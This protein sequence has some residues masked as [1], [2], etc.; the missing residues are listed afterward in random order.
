MQELSGGTYCGRPLE[1]HAGASTASSAQKCIEEAMAADNVEPSKRVRLPL[2]MGY[3]RR[4]LRCMP[5]SAELHRAAGAMGG[6]G[7]GSV[8]EGAENSV[9]SLSGV[10]NSASS[11]Q[12]KPQSQEK[13]EEAAAE[14]RSHSSSSTAAVTY[15]K[16]MVKSAVV[17]S[18]KAA[19]ASSV[20]KPVVA[21]A[22]E[23]CMDVARPK[24]S[25]MEEATASEKDTSASCRKSVSK[26]VMQVPS[27]SSAADE[28]KQFPQ[29]WLS[30][31][32]LD[33]SVEKQYSVFCARQQVRVSLV[34][35]VS[36]TRSS[37]RFVL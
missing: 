23:S 29:H 18:E 1:M 3:K 8:P 9:Q 27:V 16:M 22:E 37:G 10:E 15:L 31:Q 34:A 5:K 12:H 26:A 35:A 6:N 17:L 36:C 7:L 28:Q 30:L 20:Q 4:M 11:S 19:E 25:C 33:S 2:H 21:T 13:L 14:R 24:G 32:F